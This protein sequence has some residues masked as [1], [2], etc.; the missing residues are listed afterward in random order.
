M[1]HK[2]PTLQRHGNGDLQRAGNR[3]LSMTRCILQHQP[4]SRQQQTPDITPYLVNHEF[5]RAECL[6]LPCYWRAARV[7]R[8]AH[9]A[10]G[11]ALPHNQRPP[12]AAAAAGAAAV[13]DDD[14]E[15]PVPALWISVAALE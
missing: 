6:V 5:P 8:R 12:A 7:R 10:H 2:H 9:A 11:P 15:S 3:L 13:A 1:T 14:D 4:I